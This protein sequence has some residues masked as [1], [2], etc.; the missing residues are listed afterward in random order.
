MYLGKTCSRSKL[1]SNEKQGMA[2]KLKESKLSLREPRVSLFTI[3]SG[4]IF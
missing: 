3:I 1:S 2:V 4:E